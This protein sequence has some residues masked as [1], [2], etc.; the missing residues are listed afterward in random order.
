TGF[1]PIPARPDHPYE[2][3]T[4]T[5]GAGYRLACVGSPLWDGLFGGAGTPPLRT[6][7]MAGLAILKHT[8][9]L[10]DEVLCERWVE[11]PYFQYLCG[12]EYFRHEL[13]FDRTSMTRW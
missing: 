9:N 2:A 5:S 13:S 7:L 11:N 4:G 3:R 6:R 1:I 8:F 12:Q 10:S